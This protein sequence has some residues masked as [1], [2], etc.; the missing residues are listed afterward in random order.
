MPRLIIKSHRPWQGI[1]SVTALSVV[2]ALVTWQMLD[3]SYW[4]I[5]SSMTGRNNDERTLIDANRQ[6]LDQNQ[7]LNS[8]LLM[9]E[10]TTKV[11]KD[12]AVML[13]KEMIALQDQIYKLKRELE[14]YQG[15][16]DSARKTVGMDIHGVYIEPAGSSNRYLLKLVFTH[17]AKN[18]TV[19]K[20]RLAVTIV[21]TQNGEQ[22]RLELGSLL[23]EKTDFGFEIKSFKRLEYEFGLDE[24]FVAK[25]VIVRVNPTIGGEPPLSKTYDWPI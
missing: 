12:T 22:R 10:Q 14:F 11:D 6:L 15:A 21:G 20:G 4:R 25:Q 19:M 3:T 23:E 24:D 18:D 7:D 5:I 13:Q 2:I 1:I 16:M 9:L 17:V 8:R